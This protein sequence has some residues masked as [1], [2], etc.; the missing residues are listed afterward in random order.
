MKNTKQNAIF[1]LNNIL[2]SALDKNSE[3]VKF[4]TEEND[5]LAPYVDK[6]LKKEYKNILKKGAYKHEREKDANPTDAALYLY[7]NDAPCAYWEYVRLLKDDPDNLEYI[8]NATMCLI[9]MKAYSAAIKHFVPKLLPHKETDLQALGLI[10]GAYFGLSDYYEKAI[11]LYE[12]YLKHDPE[13]YGYHFRLAFLYE[14]IYQDQKLDIQIKYAKNALKTPE[15]INLVYTL[16]AKL[17]YRKGDKKTCKEYLDKM[18]ANNPSAADKVTYSR[19]LTKEGHIAEGYGLYRCRFET[20]NVTYPDKLLPEKRW[21]GK[22]DISNSTVIV[23]YEQ[24]FGDSVMFCRYIPEIAKKAKKVIFVVQ[25]NLIPILKSSGFDKY[26]EILSHEADLMGNVGL[27]DYN[28]SVMYSGGSGMTRIPHDY[29]IPLMDTPYLV[30]ESPDRMTEASGYLSVD[31]DKVNEFRKKYINKNKK[32]KIGLSYHGSKAS[33]VTYRDI[34][35]KKFLPLFKMEGVEFYSFQ[36][37]QYAD[38]LQELDKSIKI[39]DLGKVFNNFEDTACAMNCMDLI[40]STDNVVMNLA[41]ALSIKTYGLFNV[42]T[43]SRWYKTQ[44]DDIGWYK[45]VKPFQAKT[46]NDWDNLMLDI[47]EQLIKDFNL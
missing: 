25:K 21:D 23:H 19:F 5:K 29:H 45:S 13:N 30:G 2:L 33:I 34:S 39:T 31:S 44:G 20:S 41:G 9:N 37:D 16:L 18:M 26:C 43:E 22:A 3:L 28:K 47:R 17:Y 35:V 24:G 15:N 46:F 10:A 14:R 1:N 36:S 11:P 40:I 8:K 4:I 12:E 27:K 6:D 38:E 32:I 7:Q 42:I